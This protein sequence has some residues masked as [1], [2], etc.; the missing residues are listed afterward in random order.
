MTR[1]LLLGCGYDMSGFKPEMPSDD[2]C[3][4]GQ[5]KAMHAQNASPRAGIAF[6]TEGRG[7]LNRDP[8]AYLGRQ[9]AVSVFLALM[10]E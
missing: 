5:A 4:G 1:N 8:R 2:I 10:L 3:R 7:F 6:P 9:N